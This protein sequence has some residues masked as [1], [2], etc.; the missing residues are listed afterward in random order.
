MMRYSLSFGNCTPC[1]SLGVAPC[2]SGT[3]NPFDASQDRHSNHHKTIHLIIYLSSACIISLTLT[4][5][6]AACLHPI[7]P[8]PLLQRRRRTEICLQHSLHPRAQ[9]GE[10]T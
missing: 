10:S 9:A 6:T 2:P 7:S 8:T 1:I 4:I 3:P 5:S